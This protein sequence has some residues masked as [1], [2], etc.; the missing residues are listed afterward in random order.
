MRKIVFLA[1]PLAVAACSAEEAAEDTIIAP[2]AE[3]AT[4]NGSPAGTYEV[5]DADGNASIVTL[6]PDGTY[7]QITPDGTDSAM[8]TYFIDGDQT[9]FKV[10]TVGSEPLCYVEGPANEDGSYAATVDGIELTIRPYVSEASGEA[11]E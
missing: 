1:V 8:G 2:T 11:E 6:N 5:A 3:F 10:R 4:A 9:C 7:S